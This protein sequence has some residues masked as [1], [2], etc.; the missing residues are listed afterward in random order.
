M[1]VCMFSSSLSIKIQYNQQIPVIDW[2]IQILSVYKSSRLTASDNNMM[3]FRQQ[4]CL[5]L[6][7][8]WISPPNQRPGHIWKC[9]SLIQLKHSYML[10]INKKN[11]HA[12]LWHESPLVNFRVNLTCFDKDSVDAN[13][14]IAMLCWNSSWAYDL[15]TD[16]YYF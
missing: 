6:E 16:Y 12:F 9:N 3:A 2:H 8:P 10:F 13:D 4:I 7:L 5:Q 14:R 11:K 15:M 1:N